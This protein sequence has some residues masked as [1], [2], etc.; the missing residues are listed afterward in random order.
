MRSPSRIKFKLK[1]K[2]IFIGII[3]F[4]L[5]LLILIDCRMRPLVNK[6][7]V[8]QGKTIATKIVSTA[9]YDALNADNFTY[10]TLVK[11]SK[12]NDGSVASIESNMAEINRLQAKITYNINTQFKEISDER[13]E[14][15]TGTLTGVNMLYGRGPTLSFKIQPVGYVDSKLV[16]KFTS[17]GVNQTL[18]QIILE[19]NGSASAIIPGFP[20]QIDVNVNYLIAETIIVGNIPESYTYITGDDRGDLD[21]I[22][23]YR[24]NVS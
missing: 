17:A 16:S 4:L 20:A 10:E 12:N 23:D 19:V 14:L 15:S 13:I 22:L 1:K 5:V 21:K 24:K 2:Y 7:A 18:H 9:V 8:Y 6:M 11:V 3:V